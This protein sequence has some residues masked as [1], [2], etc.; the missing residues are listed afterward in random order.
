M[1]RTSVRGGYVSTAAWL[2]QLCSLSLL[3][4]SLGTVSASAPS[5]SGD[6]VA[7]EWDATTHPRSLSVGE[8]SSIA[9]AVPNPN[10]PTVAGC[11][12]TVL[13][14]DN[15]TS[16]NERAPNGN[17]LFGRAVY[18]ITAAEAVASGLT[19]GLSPGAIGWHY[20]TAP[21]AIATGTL[22]V[23]LQNTADTTNTKST[24]WDTAILGMTVVHNSDSTTLPNTT[25]PFDITFTGGSPFTYT[26]GGLYVAF[27]WQWA[28]PATSVGLVACNAALTNGLKGAQSNVSAPTTLA[29]TNLRPETRLTRAVATVFND[30][31]VDYVI[32]LGSLPQPLVG[33]QTVQAVVTNR[34]VNA[35]NNL[36]V[37]F[38]LTGVETFTN[39]QI[40]PSLAACGG[41][42]VVTFAPF[43]PAA[44]GSDTV[45]VSV[46]SDD[47]IS[48]NSKTRPLNETFNLYSYK[49]PGT[50]ANGGVGLSGAT[51]VFVGKMTTTAAARIAAVNLEFFATSATTY[52]VAIYPNSAGVPGLVPLYVDAVDRT[53]TA[54]GPVTIT[55]PSPVPVGPGTFYVGIQQTNTQNASVSY[56]NE[57]PIRTASFYL[58]SPNPPLA[59]FDFAPSNNFKLNIGATLVQCATP[60]DCD[61]NNACIDD[62]CANQL[63]THAINNANSCDEGNPC[64][65]PDICSAGTC[66][67]GPNPCIDGDACTNDVC[68][69]Q[70][71]CTYT[72]VDCNDNNSCTDDSC[73][74]ATGCAHSHNTT[75]CTDNNP[76]TIADACSGGACLS[77]SGALPALA[78]FCNDAGIAIPDVGAATPYPSAIVVTGQPSYLCSATVGLSG[79]G[80]T[81]P[82]DIDVLLARLTGANALILSD[83]GGAT[84]VT[85]VDLTL[86]DAAATSL[87]DEGPIVSGAFAPTNIGGGDVFPEPAPAPTGG[88][89]LSVFVGTNPNGTWDLWVDDEFQPEAGSLSGWCINLVSVCTADTD[90]NDGVVCTDEMCVDGWCAHPNNTQ[91]CDDGNACTANDI[92]ANGI[93]LGDPPP[94]CDDGDAC[95]ANNCNPATGACENP[96]AICN[97]GNSCTDDSC[98]SATGCVFTANDGNTCSDNSVCTPSDLCQ[99]GLC[100]GQNPTTCTPDANTCTTEACDPAT[101]ACGSTPNTIPCDDGNP[102]TTADTCGGGRCNGGP[103][104]DCDDNNLCSADSCSPAVRCIHT[105]TAAACEDNNPCTDD[106]CDPASGCFNTGNAAACDD[107]DVCTNG[108]A[109]GPRFTETF[110]GVTIPDLPATWTTTVTGIGD[111]WTTVDTSSDTA[112]NA[113]F[114]YDGGSVA[115]EVLI[116][117]PIMISSPAATLT[118]RNRW[119]FESEAGFNF[120]GGVLEIAIGGGVF[121]D[122]ESAGGSFVNGGYTGEI[123]AEYSNPLAGRSAWGGVSTGYPDYLTTVVN[124]PATAAGQSIRLQWRIGTDLSVGDLGQNIDS[125]VLVDGPHTCNPGTPISCDDGNVCSDDS[126][127]PVNGCQHANGTSPCDDGNACTTGDTCGDGLCRPG[128]GTLGCDD[129]NT[130]TDDSC[131]P[132]SGCVTTNN[133]ASCD[134]GS[135]CTLG[136]NCAGGTCNGASV[137]DCDDGD[138]CTAD[139]CNP[140][141]GCVHADTTAACND[142]NVCTVDSCSPASGCLHANNAIACDDANACTT[143]DTCEGGIC[144]PGAGGLNC[145]DNS[146]CTADTCN[147]ASGCV[148]TVTA[149]LDNDGLGDACDNCPTIS[150]IDQLD[151]DG[152]GLGNLCDNCETVAN[153]DQANADGDSLGNACDACPFDAQ[154]DGDGDGVCG[155]VDNCPT[156]A[157]ASQFDLDGDGLG[158]SC[159]PDRDGDAVPNADDCAPDARGTSEVPGEA[160]GLRFDADKQTLHW[161]G[162]TQGHL[163]G[164]YRGSVAP[165]AAFAYTHECLVASV[166]QHSAVEPTTPAPD[167]LFYYLAAGRNSCGDGSLGSGAG[168]P[169]PQQPACT[170]DPAA[171]GDGDGTRDLDDVCA[172]VADPAQADTDGDRLGDACDACPLDPSND[173][174]GDGACAGVDNCPTV[175]NADQMNTDGDA[176]GDACDA[177]PLDPE[178]DAD[179][180]G[181][182]RDVDNC[183]AIANAGQANADGD[184]LGDAC[185]NC[186]GIANLDQLNADNDA[187]GDVCDA[188]PLDAQNDVDGDG[189]CGDV[190]NCPTTANAGQANADG[191]AMGDACDACPF[192]VANDIDG[193]GVC[194][195]VD[196]CPTIANPTQ[197]NADNDALGD[198]CDACPLDAQNDVDGDGACGNVDNCPTVAN[199]TQTDIDGDTVGD[200]CDNCR[201]VAN[202]GQQ[203]ANGNGVGDAC[204]TARVGAWT[205][206]LT[207]TVGA[208]DDR[209][210]VFMAGFGNSSDVPVNAVS[211]G[212]QSM[213]RID[214][215]VA[216]SPMVVRIELWYLREAGIAAAT[217]G[218]FVVTF[219]G[220]TPSDPS[221]AAATYGN[222]DQLSPIFASTVNS[223]NGSTPNPLP[224]PVAVTADGFALAA[225]ISDRRGS[226]VWGNGWTE[227]TDQDLQSSSSTTADHPATVDGTDTASA[228]ASNQKAQVI[229]VVSL[230]VAR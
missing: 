96:A 140:A 74:P 65:S 211:Y 171:D 61:D 116:G 198:A 137:L 91:A 30:A 14:S 136:D 8:A 88:A 45:R 27:D 181:V 153:T 78:Q 38:N 114:G 36:P 228:T 90:C 48:N 128:T 191:D 127:D 60:A 220:T 9:Q 173:A 126:C 18:L 130:C 92:C 111:P 177:C 57:T 172:A 169:R 49:H 83:V 229:V 131:N 97:D 44:I 146:V 26:G 51:G 2:R 28:G 144:Q 104:L 165:G 107:G 7:G 143:G 221:F 218:T 35:L 145:D 158:D 175:A 219:G 168:G 89:A 201:K 69:G 54:A 186:P 41:Q 81:L 122:I 187:L 200:A 68:G 154:N 170:S 47:V 142:S 25:A 162:A 12:V 217:N 138:L 183:P 31:S 62:I 11:P 208:G 24:T 132:A 152:D 67:P 156:V 230:S 166:P 135:V 37:T 52:R 16:G 202:A 59:W 34:A 204:V 71:D 179:G 210:L 63:C 133:S 23:Y 113:A 148:H 196:S 193:D 6:E 150:N 73:V 110:D 119:H 141:S 56:D 98:N 163:D 209:L 184:T 42:A 224:T 203:D 15:S 216:G 101:G 55:L 182:C 64:T 93:C 76:C 46:P 117:P 79:I 180:D 39:T 155:D 189:A 199:A 149:D 123:S 85:G 20:S 95:T 129:N 157:N 40:V 5:L 226:F 147:P 215:T 80:H 87:P 139:S 167:E 124:L 192:D 1:S 17:F 19:A 120:D 33:P 164:L 125:I 176:L 58:A 29:A 205:T 121:T 84:P 161:D 106:G 134:D 227:G 225:A 50:T 159:D 115:D 105:D 66:L 108:D 3:A 102:C 112:P 118:F 151:T 99:N 207:H 13:P 4:I 212:G 21:G 10:A 222:V 185:D 223:T 32:S 94:A 86:S 43:T 197:D 214:G 72:A 188:C 213:T 178:N 22:I 82:D 53:V 70:G 160:S 109:C 100:V 77:G 75:P 103:P 190:D 195:D 174:D 194:G 206:G